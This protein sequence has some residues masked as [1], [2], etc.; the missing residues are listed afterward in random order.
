MP[1]HE[2]STINGGIPSRQPT[3]ITRV[4]PP[5]RGAFIASSINGMIKAAAELVK[6]IDSE[7]K[8]IPGHG[9]L[10]NQSELQAYHDMLVTAGNRIGKLVKEGK[11]LEE[12][13]ADNPTEGLME[14][15]KESP[16][17]AIFVKVVYM[18]LSKQ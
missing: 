2:A 11:T 8:I 13:L 18:D 6:I 9:P 17:P 3:S 14:I 10:S 15:G 7:T 4:N 12:V 1:W 5:T 16:D